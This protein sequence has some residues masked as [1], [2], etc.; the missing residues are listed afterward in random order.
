VCVLP[1]GKLLFSV[2][3]IGICLEGTGPGTN[4]DA[5]LKTSRIRYGTTEPKLFKVGTLRGDI[6]AGVVEVYGETLTGESGLALV[7]F[8]LEDSSDFTLPAGAEEWLSLRFQLLGAAT[9]TSYQVKALPGTTRQRLISVTVACNDRETNKYGRQSNERGSARARAEALF[10]ADRA[11]DE[12]LFE[13]FTSTG[14][15]KTLV[16]IEE[17][18][19]SEVGRPTKTSDFGGTL[20]VIMRTVT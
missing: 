8:T 16:V 3:T 15:V 9:L 17:A 12:V 18:T 10:A 1:S 2:P 11:G 4:R 7:G 20:T 13:E 5:W 14:T 19:Y 6:S